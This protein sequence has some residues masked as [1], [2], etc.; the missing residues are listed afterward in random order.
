MLEVLEAAQGAGQKSQQDAQIGQG[1]IFD[2]GGFGDGPAAFAKPAH[3][4][5]PTIEFE[6][7]ELLA[8]ERESIGVFISEHPLKRVREAI[9]AKADC[10]CSEVIDR[11]DGE[12]IRVGGMISAA[13]KI[14]TRTGSQVM[15]ANLDDLE[16]SLEVVAFEKTLATAEG[17]LGVDEIVLVRGR[18]D[19]KEAGKVCVIVQDVER[20]DPSDEEID[21]ARA[22]A[23]KAAEPPAPL[24]LRLDAALLPAAVIED[25]KRLFADYRGDSEVVLEMQTR[26]GARRLRLGEGYRV[27]ARNAG[28]QAELDRL[29]GDARAPVASA[30]A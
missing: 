16:G 1:S 5:I 20:F 11:K 18:V 9:L 13:K 23:V 4:P 2:L 19:H 15:F 25:L 8:M 28:L 14:R 26:A 7:Q 27:A 10:A 6:R 17:A 29:L 30:A 21:R 22:A 3:P 24:T 12:W